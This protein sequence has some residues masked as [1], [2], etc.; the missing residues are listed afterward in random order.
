MNGK[1]IV[2]I[3]ILS[4]FIPD[5]CRSQV[6]FSEVDMGCVNAFKLND[7]KIYSSRNDLYS[8][9]SL[10]E[11]CN[12][13]ELP[14]IDFDQYHMIAIK[15][16]SG[17]CVMPEVSMQL[18]KEDGNCVFKLLVSK[19]GNCKALFLK[20]VWVLVGKTECSN[21]LVEITRQE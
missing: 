6:P 18:Q 19:G 15:V 5:I 16:Q 11:D 13:D 3:A 4:F 7:V 2:V 17:G 9:M 14:E 10:F 12:R 8:N 20:S 1:T 21:F